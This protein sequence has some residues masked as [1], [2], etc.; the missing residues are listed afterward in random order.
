MSLVE[1]MMICVSFAD[2]EQHRKTNNNRKPDSF[3]IYYWCLILGLDTGRNREPGE[4]N[5]FL[6]QGRKE[7]L[8]LFQGNPINRRASFKE[9]SAFISKHPDQWREAQRHVVPIKRMQTGKISE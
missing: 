1:K 5:A 4:I 9:S 3:F 8:A 2:S 7:H 6:L